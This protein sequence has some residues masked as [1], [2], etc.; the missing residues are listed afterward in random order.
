[1]YMFVVRCIDFPFST[2]C[3]LDFGILGGSMS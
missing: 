2:I 3:L 1:M